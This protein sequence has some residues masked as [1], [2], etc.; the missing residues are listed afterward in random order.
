MVK[1][2]DREMVNTRH[3]SCD[4]GAFE[5]GHP[6]IYIEISPSENQAHCPYCNKLFIYKEPNT[7]QA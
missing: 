5:L 6:K 7:K 2:A 4:G 1:P 3:I